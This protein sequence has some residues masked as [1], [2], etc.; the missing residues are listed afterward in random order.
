MV[1]LRERAERG[2]PLSLWGYSRRGFRR[3][4]DT[5][6]SLRHFSE[7][8]RFLV[9]FVIYS[10][11]LMAVIA[12]AAVYAERTIGFAAADLTRMFIILQISSAGGALIFGW[13]QDRLGAKPTVQLTLVLWVA[14]AVSAYLTTSKTTFLYVA[15]A[16]GLGIGSLQ[17]A[18][19]AIVGLFSPPS[20]AGEFF[21]FWGLAQRAA[22]ILGSV[23]FGA[24]SSLSGSQ[25]TAILSTGAFFVVGL[26]AMTWISI[27]RGRAAAESWQA[28]A[29]STPS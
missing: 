14:V 2:P 19:R 15:L 1:L 8:A 6:V 11:G 17:S 22:Y 13:V 28:P 24:F 16:A 26:I 9:V 29:A 25:R 20:K 10:S 27:E 3:L 5:L 21:G 23:A 12:Y 7:L 18:S 4:R